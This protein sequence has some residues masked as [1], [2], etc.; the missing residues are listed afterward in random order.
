MINQ[1]TAQASHTFI[2][3]CIEQGLVLSP[4]PNSPLGLLVEESVHPDIALAADYFT[5]SNDNPE[6]WLTA[7]AP[8]TEFSGNVDTHA[9]TLDDASTVI[10]NSVAK[11]INI[12]R[13]VVNPAVVKVIKDIQHAFDQSQLG[14]S[15][16]IGMRFTDENSLLNS[17]D[18]ISMVNGAASSKVLNKVDGVGAFKELTKSEILTLLKTNVDSIDVDV[19]KWISATGESRIKEIFE[20][21]FVW[22]N[23]DIKRDLSD[24]DFAIGVFLFANHIIKNEDTLEHVNN[25]SLTELR[26]IL[27]TMINQSAIFIKGRLDSLKRDSERGQLIHSYPRATNINKGDYTENNQVIINR[28]MFEDFISKGGN[29][30]MI[31]GNTLMDSR[32]YTVDAILTN[33][34]KAERLWES[35]MLNL[36]N[37]V[38]SNRLNIFKRTIISSMG[39]WIK[40]HDDFSISH[41]NIIMAIRSHVSKIDYSHLNDIYN[42]VL[43]ILDKTLFNDSDAVKYLRIMNTYAEQY[44]NLDIRQIATLAATEYVSA[45]VSSMILVEK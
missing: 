44:P 34:K 29:I 19:A 31:Y 2:E 40:D 8:H 32:G 27:S 14:V 26:A 24:I 9:Q 33:G 42:T 43:N 37:Q 7:F 38:D 30:E 4:A 12:A 15:A 35:H 22:S 23:T 3:T 11:T 5:N 10:A 1:N 41:D 28:S 13:N 25:I 45:W 18:F 39:Q 17:V 6:I 21:S 36:R 16:N 20:I